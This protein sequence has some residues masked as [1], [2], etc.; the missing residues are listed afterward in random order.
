MSTENSIQ[1]PDVWLTDTS[2]FIFQAYFGWPDRFYD[3]EGNSVNAVVGFFQTIIKWLE[4]QQPNYWVC[5]FDHSLFSGYRHQIDPSY[6]ANRALPDTALAYQLQ[7]C[8]LLTQLLGIRTLYSDKYEA[9]DLLYSAQAKWFQDRPVTVMTADKDLAQMLRFEDIWWNSKKPEVLTYSQMI[10]YWG[11]ECHRIS[12]LLALTGDVSDN[13]SGVPGIGNKTA[14]KLLQS[15]SSL[16]ELLENLDDLKKTGIRN[17]R[18]ITSNLSHLKSLVE[19]NLLLTRLADNAPIGR[20]P[21]KWS[22]ER[23]KLK[24]VWD[25]CDQYNIP[26]RMQNDL[27][28]LIE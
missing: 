22:F 21:G 27:K 13:I 3:D 23:I 5:A 17:L 9:D 4:Y 26:K 25:F 6:K 15:F 2:I 7:S 19:N 1:L 11:T 28:A 16:D 8:E 14:A 24:Q 18:A 12:E 20:Q 10:N